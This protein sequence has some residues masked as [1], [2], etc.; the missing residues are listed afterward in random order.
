MSRTA[1]QRRTNTLTLSFTCTTARLNSNLNDDLRIPN[2]RA[3]SISLYRCY[4]NQTI[5]KTFKTQSLK[6][7]VFITELKLWSL[8]LRFKN[9]LNIVWSHWQ[10]YGYLSR[11][12]TNLAKYRIFI[13][14]FI[15]LSL[16]RKKQIRYKDHDI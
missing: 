3:Q 7:F 13:I 11:V 16:P 10:W 14:N 8:F 1:C 9:L 6:Q 5:N 15:V 12:L 4:R 2:A